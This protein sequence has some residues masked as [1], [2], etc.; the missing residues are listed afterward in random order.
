MRKCPRC[1]VEML[2]DFLL[3][4]GREP[5]TLNKMG[6]LFGSE[7]SSYLKAAVCPECGEVSIF[8]PTVAGL[9]RWIEKEPEK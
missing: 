1:D 9:E 3:R 6:K 8:L 4:A 7:V 2:E 5:V